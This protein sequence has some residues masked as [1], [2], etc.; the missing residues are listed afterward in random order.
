MTLQP[1]RDS[2]LQEFHRGWL[3]AVLLFVAVSRGSAIRREGADS[4]R[5]SILSPCGNCVELGKAEHSATP[6]FNLGDL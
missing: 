3:A 5:P 6:T 1:D 2:I 4:A